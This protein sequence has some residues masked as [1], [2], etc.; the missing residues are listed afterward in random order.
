MGWATMGMGWATMGWATMGYGLW[1]VCV[2][3]GGGH[4]GVEI[5]TAHSQFQFQSRACMGLWAL[6]V[7]GFTVQALWAL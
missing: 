6:E 1:C 7:L 4:F 3:G 5:T 2:G